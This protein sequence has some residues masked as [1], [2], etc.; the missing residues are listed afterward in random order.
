VSEKLFLSSYENI[1]GGW[2][3]SN[4]NYEGHGIAFFSDPIITV[5]GYV[6]ANFD[7]FGN[8][9]IVMN[10]ENVDTQFQ[11][12][13]EIPNDLR[14]PMLP[15]LLDGNLSGKRPIYGSKNV[16]EWSYQFEGKRRNQCNKLIVVTS[17]G[18]FSAEKSIGFDVSVSFH[19]NSGSSAKLKFH[20]LN[21]VF[22]SDKSCEAKYWAL[23]LMNFISPFCDY[24]SD[25]DFHP[26]RISRSPI[27][28]N[29]KIDLNILTEYL[30]KD[31][32]IIIFHFK[33]NI[34]FIE[35]LPDYH[36]RKTMLLNGSSQRIITSVMIGEIPSKNSNNKLNDYEN[37][38]PFQFLDM[39]GLATGTE[40]GAPWIELRDACG[41]LVYRSHSEL[42]APWFST[43]HK[44]IDES[45]HH[46]IGSLLT[47]SQYSLHTGYSYMTAVMKHLVRSGMSGLLFEDGMAH[48]FQ[49]FD[50]LCEVF[51]L[52]TQRLDEE[53]NDEQKNRVKLELN[54]LANRIRGL[55]TLGD[56]QGQKDILFRI[57]ER[58]LNSAN[59]DRNFGLAVADLIKLFDLSDLLMVESFY[60]SNPRRD[61]RPWCGVL[62]HYRGVVMHSSYF[63]FERGIYDFQDVATIKN[64]LHDILIRIVLKMLC[65]DGTYQKAINGWRG[66]YS[67]DWVNPNIRA[68]DLGYEEQRC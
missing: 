17:D 67:L 62:S 9:E 37:W 11:N 30:D 63:D 1:V 6:S 27:H 8:K 15:V 18:V 48:L 2:F 32:R 54:S 3:H 22:V 16:S 26:L 56:N 25:L 53:L 55:S 66:R 38:F 47:R 36:K 42:N 20:I 13:C 33:N 12:F 65:Y 50:C 19:R 31:K 34:G 60:R 29:S 49:A 45:I 51:G 7:E 46:G 14:I 58:A 41:A 57:A 40:I 28:N 35:R 52:N 21:S 39:L 68:E 44:S 4:V 10:V 5:G 61:G 64:H 23:P 24:S 59:F 43:G